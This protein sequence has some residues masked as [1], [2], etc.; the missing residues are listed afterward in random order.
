MTPEEAR[1]KATAE[2]IA[3]PAHAKVMRGPGGRYDYEVSYR[4]DDMDKCLNTIFA[5]KARL[6]LELYGT[7]T[8]KQEATQ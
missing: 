2:I 5:A 6:E 1:L 3:D 7:P 8:P 4:C